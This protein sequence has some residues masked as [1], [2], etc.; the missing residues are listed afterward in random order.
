MQTPIESL[1]VLIK[2]RP[3]ETAVLFND[4][5]GAEELLRHGADPS[6]IRQKLIDAINGRTRIKYT[7]KELDNRRHLLKLIEKMDSAMR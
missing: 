5:A 3:I 6:T 1:A 2:L 7:D 4:F